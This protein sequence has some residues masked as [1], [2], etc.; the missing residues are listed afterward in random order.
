VNSPIVSPIPPCRVVLISVQLLASPKQVGLSVLDRT[1]IT[2]LSYLSEEQHL[3][4]ACK[5]E[6]TFGQYVTIFL[7]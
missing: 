1:L 7:L 6:E 3:N 2:I 5:N 4:Q